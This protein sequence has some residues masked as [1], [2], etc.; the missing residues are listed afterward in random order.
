MRISFCTLPNR[1]TIRASPRQHVGVDQQEF[2]AIGRKRCCLTALML[3]CCP[4]CIAFRGLLRNHLDANALNEFVSSS[5]NVAVQSLYVFLRQLAI[6]QSSSLRT[7]K[8][9]PHT[10]KVFYRLLATTL[11]LVDQHIARAHAGERGSAYEARL[12]TSVI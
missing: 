2:Y 5:R 11:L 7:N 9:T 6:Y 8:Q 3:W 10:Q 4:F 12:W 1:T